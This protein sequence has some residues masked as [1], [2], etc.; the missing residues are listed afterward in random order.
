MLRGFRGSASGI[1]G[2]MDVTEHDIDLHSV[3]M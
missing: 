3:K 1:M 2:F